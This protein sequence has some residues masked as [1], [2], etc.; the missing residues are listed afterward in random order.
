MRYCPIGYKPDNITYINAMISGFCNEK[1]FDSAYALLNEMTENKG[2]K[3]DVISYNVIIFR[4]CMDRRLK[5]AI[6]LF[7]DVPRRKCAPK[8]SYRI[9]FD[10]PCQPQS[11]P[12]PC[13]PAQR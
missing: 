12:T 6:E 10:G 3:P 5:E 2:C 8:V 4:F 13:R 7:E 11:G 1:D 9:L